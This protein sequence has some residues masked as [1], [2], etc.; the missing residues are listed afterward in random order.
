MALR[1]EVAVDGTPLADVRSHDEHFTF[2]RTGGLSGWADLYAKME[3]LV[4]APPV[5]ALCRTRKRDYLLSLAAQQARARDWPGMRQTVVA[6]A[7]ARAFSP[8][9]WLRLAKAAALARRE[10]ASHA[11][12]EDTP[13][14]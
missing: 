1:S 13:R 3:G 5:R 2:D 4:A 9:G 7:R 14:E 11:P 12:L 6:A 10:K 8:R